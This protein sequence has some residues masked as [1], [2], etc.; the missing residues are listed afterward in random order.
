[1][2]QPETPL[3]IAAQVQALADVVGSLAIIAGTDGEQQAAAR[4]SLYYTV[5][6][7]VTAALDLQDAAHAAALKAAREQGAR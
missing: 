1:M 4:E 7:V 3:A 6:R 5:S 2:P